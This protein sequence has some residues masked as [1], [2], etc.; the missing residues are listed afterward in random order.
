[1]YSSIADSSWPSKLILDLSKTNWLLADRLYVSGYLDGTL[2]C[3]DVVAFP[4][5]HHIWNGNDKSLRAFILE[6]I[7]P[8][9]Y[10]IASPFGTANTT[11]DG[12]R[13]PHEKLGLHAQINLLQK[14]PDVYYEPGT[15]MLTTSKEL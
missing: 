3:P 5:A 1:M 8:E 6:H 15:P 2:S 9:E 12:L 11:F 4:A 10:D 14:A 7:T 13:L